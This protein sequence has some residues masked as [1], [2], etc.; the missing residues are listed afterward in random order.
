MVW[1]P[2]V[3][4]EGKKEQEAGDDDDDDDDEVGDDISRQA[5]DNL[6]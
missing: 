4:E 5:I 1:L 2:T 3:I 6:W